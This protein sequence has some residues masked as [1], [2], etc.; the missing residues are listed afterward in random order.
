M[1]PAETA[2]TRLKYCFY[3]LF[4]LGFPFGAIACK[5][6]SQLAS[7]PVHACDHLAA[8]PE[9]PGRLS[10]VPGVTGNALAVEANVL[11]A[12]S[13]CIEAHEKYPDAPR[14]AYQLGR[15]LVGA[16]M[17]ED[18]EPFLISAG[19]KEYA[20]A[21]ALLGDMSEDPEEANDFYE[22]AAARNFLPARRY[23]EQAKK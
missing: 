13:V 20:A 2:S 4:V 9:D 15:A 19:E 21:F 1:K 23:L 6:N 8:D 18:A 3:G 10:S 22:L 7:A 12:V 17:L 16:G 5:N 14:F 11:A